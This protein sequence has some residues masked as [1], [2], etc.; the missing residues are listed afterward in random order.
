MGPPQSFEISGGPRNLT[1]S[2]T[3][4]APELRNGNITSY[5]ITCDPTAPLVP[6]AGTSFPSM[7][8]SVSLGRFTPYTNYSCQ[9]V[10]TNS[11]GPSPP[12]P[13]SIQTPE[14]G[15]SVCV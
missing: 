12:A 15:K 5:T 10:G 3:Q 14:D 11:I 4:I 9:V 7:T 8:T 6:P 1:F 2:W 13:A